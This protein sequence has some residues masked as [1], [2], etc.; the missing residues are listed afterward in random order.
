MH[1]QTVVLDQEGGPPIWNPAGSNDEYLFCD[2]FCQWTISNGITQATAA[3]AN[4]MIHMSAGGH[5]TWSGAVTASGS[6]GLSGGLMYLFGGAMLNLG[7]TGLTGWSVTPGA[8]KV[9][10]NATIVTNGITPPGGYAVGASAAA[11]TGLAGPTC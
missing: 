4:Y 6:G 1:N 7:V 10:A 8:S 9:W 2:G 3:G 5:G 11:C